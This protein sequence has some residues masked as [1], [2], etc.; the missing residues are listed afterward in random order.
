MAAIA[1][2]PSGAAGEDGPRRFTLGG[3]GS[4]RFQDHGD[5]V[6]LCDHL[7]DGHSVGVRLV[8]QNEAGESLDYARWNWWGPNRFNG[9]KDINTAARD[10]TLFQYKVCLGDYA[11]PGGVPANAIDRTCSDW[12]VAFN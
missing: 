11:K 12:A 9:C 7:E 4:A 3:A 1:L 8:Y 10:K 2:A 5:H 6:Y